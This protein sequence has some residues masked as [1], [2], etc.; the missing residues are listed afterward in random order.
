MSRDR[1]YRIWR[2]QIIKRDGCCVIC[3]S[4]KKRTAHHINSWRYF[5][6]DRY[7]IDNGVCLCNECH[8]QYHTNFKKSFRVKTDTKDWNNFLELNKYLKLKYLGN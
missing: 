6:D 2:A 1:R 4:R 3:K 8:I 7:D 5:P